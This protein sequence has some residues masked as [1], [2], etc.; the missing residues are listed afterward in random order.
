MSVVP[1]IHMVMPNI[2]S[3]LFIS[4]AGFP[5]AVSKFVSKYNAL[6]DYHTGRR[7]LKSG[8]LVMSIMGFI[9]FILL[10]SIA[11]LLAPAVLGGDTNGNTVEDVVLVIRMVS[12]ALLVVPIMSLLRGFFQGH[13]SMGPTAIS[14]V[15]EQ[16]VRITFLLSASYIVIKVLDGDIATAVAYSTFAA[17]IGGLGGLAVLIIYWIK[18]KPHLDNLIKIIEN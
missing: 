3:F 8:L 5:L 18:R 12:V 13:Q 9:G 11:P 4:T 16:L 2:Q 10:Y 7:I 14:Q 6:G 17:F 15:V 1:Y